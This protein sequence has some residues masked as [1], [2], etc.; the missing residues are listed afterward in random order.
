MID[1]A[2]HGALL[3]GVTD[4]TAALNSALSAATGLANKAVIIR[5]DCKF[6]GSAVTLPT[7]VILY[8]D[9]RLRLTSTLKVGN[10]NTVIGLGG[11]DVVQFQRGSCASIIP[12]P[13]GDAVVI[14]G[15]AIKLQNICISGAVG[16]GIRIDGANVLTG[17]VEL[18]HVYVVGKAGGSST[19]CPMLIDAAFW[20]WMNHCS[21]LSTPGTGPCLHITNTNTQHSSS[22]LIYVENTVFAGKGVLV[23]SAVSTSRG[24][25]VF[26]R[27]CHMEVAVG[28]VVTLDGR[29][30]QAGISN[31]VL[32]QFNASDSDQTLPLVHALGRV[33][34]A[35][36]VNCEFVQVA[37]DITN[38]HIEPRAPYPYGSTSGMTL[39]LSPRVP[40][41]S[42]I[43]RGTVRARAFYNQADFG[44]I[45]HLLPHDS[46][47]IDP[48]ALYTVSVAGGQL[49]P[50][51]SNT[52]SLLTGSGSA[53]FAASYIPAANDGDLFIY[54][55]WV[56]HGDVDGALGLNNDAILTAGVRNGGRPQLGLVE[57][58]TDQMKPVFDNSIDSRAGWSLYMAYGTLQGS[59]NPTAVDYNCGVRVERPTYVWKPFAVRVRAADIVGMS[60]KE[61]VRLLYTM[62]GVVPGVPAG[63]L[64]LHPHQKVF[65]GGDTS[66][67]RESGGVLKVGAALKTAQ[68]TTRPSA[69]SVGMGGQFFDTALGKPIWS[70]GAVWRDAAGVAV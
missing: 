34:S 13:T 23:D 70:N 38:L 29:N 59:A 7:D 52:A 51:G 28:P 11:P 68:G 58:G 49:A 55:V 39:D 45:P 67:E 32:D 47:L 24:G 1:I 43:Y 36:I 31:V 4:D 50:D 42:A 25:N 40:S 54:G 6:S 61:K 8:V 62:S 27:N 20:V 69:T 37:G 35:R 14:Q 17:Q 44:P 3:D 10:R 9:G 64:G 57:T 46:F 5:G 53:R 16:A 66:I 12:P 48:W 2:E 19:S 65:I 30:A 22:G 41:Q 15:A 18:D 26:F 33:D 63:A 56:K 21:F 60:A